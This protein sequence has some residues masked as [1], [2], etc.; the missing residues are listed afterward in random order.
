M[1]GRYERVGNEADTA[2]D[3]ASLRSRRSL[4]F[5]PRR[6][7]S[8]RAPSFVDTNELEAAFDDGSDSDMDD[9]TGAHDQRRLL[10]GAGGRD[11]RQVR[12]ENHFQIGDDDSDAD[13]DEEK[14]A[15]KE[16]SGV[17]S[18]PLRTSG[19][20]HEAQPVPNQQSGRM[21]GDYDF[22][23][24]YVSPHILFLCSQLVH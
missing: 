20:A 18:D 6:Q 7:N 14:K 8:Q 9:G 10:N 21:P 12:D 3:D 22:D 24:D 5:L 17:F 4:S 2:R 11:G 13:D 1:S 16:V 15:A 19:G 23:R